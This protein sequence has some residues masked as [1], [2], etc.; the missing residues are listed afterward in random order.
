MIQM[1]VSRHS[2]PERTRQRRRFSTRYMLAPNKINEKMHKYQ[3][4]IGC[5]NECFLQK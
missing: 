4:T 2:V 3:E 5:L 1:L